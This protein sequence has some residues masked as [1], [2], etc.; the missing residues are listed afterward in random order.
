MAVKKEVAWIIIAIIILWFVIGFPK[1]L[2]ESPLVASYYLLSAAAIILVGV[3]ARK[4]AAGIYS[5]KIEHE[6]WTYQRWGFYTRSHFKKPI[7]IGLIA[8]F[9]LSIFSLGAIKLLVLLQFNAENV[10]SKRILKRQG[11]RRATR[12]SEMNERDPA[13]TAAWGLYSLLLLAIIGGAILKGV[14]NLEIG[15]ILSR[16]SIFYG[17]W[18]LI[19]YSK[20]DGA[21]L[22]FGSML[23]WT[24]LVIIYI[25][26]SLIVIF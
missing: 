8:P 16:Y 2:D 19:P 17:V 26:A 21:K 5:I 18:N 13:M 23:S 1:I 20:L 11:T 10:P 12:K 4:I 15:T 14:F 22:F 9:F 3:F 24:I 7:P 25:I 6:I